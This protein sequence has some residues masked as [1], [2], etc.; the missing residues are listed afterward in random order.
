MKWEIAVAWLSR[1]DG[2]SREAAERKLADLA[3]NG[4]LYLKWE[5]QTLDSVFD[6]PPQ[7]ADFWQKAQIR[8]SKVLDPYAQRE[9][10]LL[11]FPFAEQQIW[12]EIFSRAR[13][14]P[15]RRSGP[16]GGAPGYLAKVKEKLS[17]VAPTNLT[18]QSATCRKRGPITTVPA[19]TPRLSDGW[20]RRFWGWA[21]PDKT[22]GGI[23]VG[24]V[25]CSLGFVLGFVR[26]CHLFCPFLIVYPR[27]TSNF[28]ATETEDAGSR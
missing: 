16:K 6:R 10:T 1:T 14:R 11:L 13:P 8:G 21:K 26:F 7:D 24:F 4:K 19:H 12:P 9:R 23:F 28:S 5:D 20:L 27:C 22:K 18:T 15:T 25:Q 17:N 3:G 2:V